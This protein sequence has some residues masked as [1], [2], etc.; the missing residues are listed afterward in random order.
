[1][2]R[3]SKIFISALLIVSFF[4]STSSATE[5]SYTKNQKNTITNL[6]KALVSSNT[7]KIAIAQKKYVA[8]S[9][10]AYYFV[11]LVRNH[12][13][14]VRYFK[15]IN[16]YGLPSGSTPSPEL[17]GKFKFSKNI[18]DFNSI[19]NEFDG[20]I[21]NIKFDKNGKII[22]WTMADRSNNNSIKLAERVVLVTSKFEG[23]GFKVDKGYLFKQTD[24]KGFLQL[25]IKNIS[26]A[27][28]SWSYAGGQYG[29]PDAKYLSASS[30][31]TGCLYPGQTAFLEAQIS[32]YP[33]VAKNTD[34]VFD[35]PTFN[36]CGPGSTPASATLRFT[37]N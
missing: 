36:G 26:P 17:S 11:D 18:V 14:T 37:T 6:F 12:H 25:Q 28:K 32:G 21:S 9:T 27:L 13:S 29:G 33:L 10:P 22:S 4:P 2:K 8:A 16:A 20:R 7:D 34:A 30:N 35:A 1:M 31:P 23:S 15:S 3:I 24:G 5:T 19:V